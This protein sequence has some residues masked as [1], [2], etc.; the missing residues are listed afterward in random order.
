MSFKG[1]EL[2]CMT[3]SPRYEGA[4]QSWLSQREHSAQHL[5]T[6]ASSAVPQELVE[7]AGAGPVPH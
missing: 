7:N 2:V 1:E 3:S 4:L 6:R 5:S